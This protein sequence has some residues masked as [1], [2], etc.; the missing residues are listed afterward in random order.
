VKFRRRTTF[1]F[2][3]SFVETAKV[4]IDDCVL[5]VK[6]RLDYFSDFERP[7]KRHPFAEARDAS[8]FK[9]AP[10]QAMTS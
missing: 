1:F 3:R 4:S 7:T 10:L 2:E 9:R 6:S 5:G 8:P